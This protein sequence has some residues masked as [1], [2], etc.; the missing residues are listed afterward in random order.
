MEKFPEHD[1]D[2]YH[3]HEYY[4]EHGEENQE[5]TVQDHITNLEQLLSNIEDNIKILWDQVIVPHIEP[6][7]GGPRILTKLRLN[8]YHIFLKF[9]IEKNPVYNNILHNLLKLR[10]N[11]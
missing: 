6:T 2:Y 5:L 10:H 3:N 7:N 8:D 1:D 9:M 11:T 4:L